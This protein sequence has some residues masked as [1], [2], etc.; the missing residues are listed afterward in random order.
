LLDEPSEELRRSSSKR[1]PAIIAL[2]K[3]PVDL[4]VGTECRFRAAVSDSAYMLE[5]G[6]IRWQGTMGRWPTIRRS[7]AP[8]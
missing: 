3:R 5:K 8:I 6:Q 1:S 2:K 4:V 7:S